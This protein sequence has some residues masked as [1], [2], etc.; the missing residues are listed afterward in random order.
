MT[1]NT[2]KV[3]Q[4]IVE[5]RLHELL[6]RARMSGVNEINLHPCGI[7]IIVDG[8]VTTPLMRAA[9]SLQECYHPDGGVYVASFLNRLVLCVYYKNV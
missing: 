2:S 9:V 6:R 4:K 1:E 7:E 5:A 8:I 3:S